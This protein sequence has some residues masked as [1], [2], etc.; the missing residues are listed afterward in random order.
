[1]TEYEAL[2]L[3]N[4]AVRAGMSLCD[5]QFPGWLPRMTEAVKDG[6]LRLGSCDSC[7]LAIAA[8]RAY[9]DAFRMLMDRKALDLFADGADY[10]FDRDSDQMQEALDT[11]EAWACGQPVERAYAGYDSLTLAWEWHIAARQAGVEV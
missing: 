4:G 6:R 5:E 1:M 8:Q 2:D 9:G 7:A 11:L 3:I 10:G